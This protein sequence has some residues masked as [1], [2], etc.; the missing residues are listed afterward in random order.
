MLYD[1]FVQADTITNSHCIVGDEGECRDE[2]G[3]NVEESFLL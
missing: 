3:Y 1:S 2:G